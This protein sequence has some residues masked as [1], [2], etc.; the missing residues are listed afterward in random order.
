MRC[1]SDFKSLP[2]CH[3]NSFEILI[4]AATLLAK[5]T[6]WHFWTNII[7]CEPGFVWRKTKEKK[8]KERER[9]RERESGEEMKESGSR[10]EID[11]QP[12]SE[13]INSFQLSSCYLEDYFGVSEQHFLKWHVAILRW[14]WIKTRH[15][16]LA[17]KRLERTWRYEVI[18][19]CWCGGAIPATVLAP[20]DQWEDLV[21]S[22]YLLADVLSLVTLVQV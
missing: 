12:T 21:I 18:R 10:K 20:A 22:Y 11:F 17:W 5:T 8:K 19:S 3:V 4:R 15:T 1:H 2:T 14:C 7:R 16:V 6:C 9:E 13:S